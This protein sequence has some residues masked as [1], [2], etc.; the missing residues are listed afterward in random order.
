MCHSE[1]TSY[2]YQSVGQSAYGTSG[3]DYEEARSNTFK[4]F[5]VAVA[6]LFVVIVVVLV[7]FLW[8]ASAEVQEYT[9]TN[10]EA[11]QDVS[12]SVY[13]VVVVRT[14]RKTDTTKGAEVQEYTSTNDEAGQDVSSS[15]YP[16]VVVRTARKTDTTK[17]FRSPATMRSPASTTPTT[18]TSN[19]TPTTPTR[20]SLLVGSLLCTLRGG[21]SLDTF[22]FPA[23]G[24]CAIIT[25]NSLFVIGGNRLSPPYQ[26]DLTYFLNTAI[27]HRETEYGIGIDHVFCRSD[28]LM[29][30]LIA[31][32][33]TKMYLDEMWS[34]R[35]YHYG[36]VN[37]PAILTDGSILEYVTQSAKGLQMISELMSDKMDLHLR[38]SYTILHYPLM[39]E[40]MSADIAKALMSYPVHIFVA[41]G[42]VAY[43]DYHNEHCR[44][45][46]PVL[47]SS[48]LLHPSD[49]NGTYPIRLDRV[50]SALATLKTKSATPSTFAVSLGMGGRWYIPKYPDK[51]IGTPGNYSLGHDCTKTVRGDAD[52]RKQISSIVE[53]CEDVNYNK[54][55]SIDSTF[56]AQFSYDKSDLALFTY[57]S[58]F[59]LRLKLCETKRNFT[60]LHYN[61]VADDIQYED[62]DNFCGYGSYSRLQILKRLV[63]FLAENYKSPIEERACKLIT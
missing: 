59:T 60:N 8:S 20:K 53:A 34:K 24:V 22:V 4:E 23:D 57:E 41:V 7:L 45:V 56:K 61:I 26:S 49:L 16:V 44:M 21:F 28:S 46:P 54:S 17:A 51:L 38:P 10:D 30:A 12:S 35:V 48:E 1:G 27:H 29:S 36:Q 2:Q 13:P 39:N 11:G 18:T 5:L 15:V 9:S 25:F 31:N 63:A 3:A 6:V 47:H 14:A 19:T 50:L 58:A 42:Y 52:L 62:F 40:S 37:T 43:T 55:F 33:T 32:Q